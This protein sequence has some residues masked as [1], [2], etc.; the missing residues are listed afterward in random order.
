MRCRPRLGCPIVDEIKASKRLLCAGVAKRDFPLSPNKSL[1]MAQKRRWPSKGT[2][3][4]ADRSQPQYR[5]EV[6]S[7]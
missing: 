6:A 4:E 3:K 1:L 5:N 7:Y 2:K